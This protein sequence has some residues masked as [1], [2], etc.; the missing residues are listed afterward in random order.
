MLEEAFTQGDELWRVNEETKVANWTKAM[1]H[2]AKGCKK[3]MMVNNVLRSELAG[4]LNLKLVRIND[5]LSGIAECTCAHYVY[6]L[7]EQVQTCITDLIRQAGPKA[8]MI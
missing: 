8:V 6:E 3:G 4:S 1:R 5:Q 2:E 7:T